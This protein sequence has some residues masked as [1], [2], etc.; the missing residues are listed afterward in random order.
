VLVLA[1]D[2]PT[3]GVEVDVA[4]RKLSAS[5][6]TINTITGAVERIWSRTLDWAERSPAEF[7]LVIILLMFI[8]VQLRKTKV[9][10]AAMIIEYDLRREEIRNQEPP[11]PLPL[12]PEPRE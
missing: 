9:T 3:S 10:S 12:P 7:A 11:L 4:G 5:H 6:E 2:G 8:V 1:A